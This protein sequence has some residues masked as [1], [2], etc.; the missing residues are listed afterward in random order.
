MKRLREAVRR[1]GPEFG[2]GGWLLYLDNVPVHSTLPICDFLTK[3]ETMLILCTLYSPEFAPA[4]FF[5]IT[6]LK[7]LMKG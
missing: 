2:G 4:D 6:K 3:C 7:S 5:L 1:K